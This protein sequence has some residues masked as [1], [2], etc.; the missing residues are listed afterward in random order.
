MKSKKIIYVALAIIL[1][2]IS[3]IIIGYIMNNKD[4][5]DK[6]KF[7]YEDLIV[8]NLK[9]GMSEEEVISIMGEPD[10]ISDGSPLNIFGTE[11]I[12]KYDELS[13]SFLKHDDNMLLS[14]VETLSS[15]YTFTR[16]L[17]VGDS[18]DKVI[19]SFY[20]DNEYREAFSRGQY[21]YGTYTSNDYEKVKETGKVENAYINKFNYD[22]D[23]ENSHYMIE[24]NYL[25]PP[26][27]MEYATELDR[28]GLLIF[29]VNSDDIVER[30]RWNYYPSRSNPNN[31]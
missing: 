21:L 12:Y 6:S 15:S 8:D 31:Q 26:Y 2:V 17:K 24:Y 19:N 1:I 11:K 30:I 22:P 18:K 7:S 25:E 3:G 13:L 27:Q 16:G 10:K 9:Y 23:K 20:N 14:G 29:D 4:K 28:R 5:S